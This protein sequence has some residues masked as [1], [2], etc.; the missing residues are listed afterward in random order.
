MQEPRIPGTPGC[1]PMTKTGRGGGTIP[2]TVLYVWNAMPD[3]GKYYFRILKPAKDDNHYLHKDSIWSHQSKMRQAQQDRDY[4]PREET[5]VWNATLE[6][7]WLASIRGGNQ[8]SIFWFQ[9]QC[10]LCD[11]CQ[12]MLCIFASDLDLVFQGQNFL[13]VLSH[14]L[15]NMLLPQKVTGWLLP[16]HKITLNGLWELKEEENHVD[17]DLLTKATWYNNFPLDETVP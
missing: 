8:A 4:V 5:V 13:H 15:T 3:A 6:F 17:G 7:P 11:K 16:E 1:K 10:P 9:S 14:S 12:D 2:S